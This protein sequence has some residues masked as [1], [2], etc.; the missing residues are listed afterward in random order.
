MTSR[1]RNFADVFFA[2]RLTLDKSRRS[3]DGYMAIHAR[4]ARSGIY[5][6][7]G[8]EIDPTGQH[9]A[10]DQVVSVYRPADEVFSK[11]SLGSFVGKPITDDHPD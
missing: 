3:A 10:A 1:A 4:A 2:D 8:S 6:Y 9:F 11:E 5:Q 7:L